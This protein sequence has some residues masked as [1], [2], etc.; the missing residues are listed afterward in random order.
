MKALALLALAA[1]PAALAL[2]DREKHLLSPP[3]PKQAARRQLL[4]DDVHALGRRQLNGTGLETATVSGLTLTEEATPTTGFATA[5]A[6]TRTATG[7]SATAP[8]PTSTTGG[9]DP[10]AIFDSSVRGTLFEVSEVRNCIRCA[11]LL[12]PCSSAGRGSPSRRDRG[13]LASARRVRAAC[14]RSRARR[15]LARLS[16]SPT[17]S[18][19]PSRPSH[20]T[21]RFR[22]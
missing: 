3:A 11:V 18:A 22:C 15:R 13:R 21:C 1:T 10:C 16:P 20:R 6:A 14:D 9:G 2:L 12:P 4:A 19:L 17:L 5:T 7:S 8:S